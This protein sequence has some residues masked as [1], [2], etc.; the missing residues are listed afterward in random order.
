MRNIFAIVITYNTE[1]DQFKRQFDSLRRQF[2][3]IIYIDN[4]SADFYLI[5]KFLSTQEDVLL[6][7]NVDNMGLG[8]AQNQGVRLAIDAGCSHVVILD[9]DSVLSETFVE[10][11]LLEEFN[12]INSGEKVGALGPV[13]INEITGEQYP[14]TKYV[15][16]FIK[17]LTPQNNPVEASFLISSGAMI[18][19][20][21]FNE[22]GYMNESLFIDYIDVEWSFR[23]INKGFKLYAVPSV[24]MKHSIGD[25]RTSIL[26]RTISVHSPLRRYYL[27][28]NGI[29]M[30]RCSYIAWGYK[31]REL[32]FLILR[33]FI[34]AFLSSN[35]EL[36]IKYSLLGLIHGLKNKYGKCDR[37]F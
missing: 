26:G 17:R 7:E 27:N 11:M 19:S 31:L 36:Y 1:F 10:Q 6:V 32:V 14:I 8:Y 21:V 34:F 12:L 37:V 2:E 18:R 33:F 30:L 3:K 24:K 23:A 13:Y 15:G 16:P 28:R 9:D 22:V 35:R 29:F 20:E 25:R 4:N 5:K